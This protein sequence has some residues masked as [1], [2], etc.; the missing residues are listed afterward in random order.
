MSE[1]VKFKISEELKNLQDEVFKKISKSGKIK[2][3]INEVTKAIERG[4]AKLVA[5]AEDVTPAEIVMH[6]PVIAKEKKIPFTYFKTKA[7]LGKAVGISAK[8]SS[9]AIIDAGVSQKELSSLIN[10]ISDM[11]G[12]KEA[13]KADAKKETPKA[14]VKAEVKKEEPK[15]EVKA[16][17]KKEEPKTEVKKEEIKK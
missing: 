5:I 12:G 2:I 17:V 15:T 14:E 13:P 16:E 3:G 10:K 1:Y 11:I 8:A 7:D 4:T 9:I 6:L